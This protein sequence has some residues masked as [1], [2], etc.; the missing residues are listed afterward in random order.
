MLELAIQKQHILCERN[1]VKRLYEVLKTYQVYFTQIIN[2]SDAV[3]GLG[4]LSRLRSGNWTGVCVPTW[5]PLLKPC[6]FIPF[7]R[8]FQWHRRALQTL[9][10]YLNIPYLTLLKSIVSNPD[11]FELC[12]TLCW[13]IVD[14]TTLWLFGLYFEIYEYIVVISMV[15]I[16]VGLYNFKI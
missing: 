3:I 14:V 2:Y 15:L 8:V 16:N 11:E 4:W 10:V 1:S 5:V 9:P 7:H 6:L 12:S 13:S